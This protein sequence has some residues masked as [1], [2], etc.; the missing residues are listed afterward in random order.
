ME[1]KFV[2]VDD[3][4]IRIYDSFILYKSDLSQYTDTIGSQH[5]TLLHVD[6]LFND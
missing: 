6:D 2:R 4:E 3:K 5:S 1:K